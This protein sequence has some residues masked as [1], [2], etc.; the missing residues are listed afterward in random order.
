MFNGAMQR[1]IGK[2]IGEILLERGII[3][4][5][6]LDQALA[7]GKQTGKRL[8]EALVE[9]G[10]ISRD[11]VYLA[12]GVQ[13]GVNQV[14]L[15]PDMIDAEMVKRYPPKILRA[16]S[17]LPLIEVGEEVVLL[18]ADPMATEGVDKLREACPGKTFT[19]QL[20][21]RGQIDL[22]LEA[23]F[24][25]SRMQAETET[26]SALDQAIPSEQPSSLVS[27]KAILWMLGQAIAA[28]GDLLIA[29]RGSGG[30]AALILTPS[31]QQVL[32]EFE[33]AIF[34]GLFNLIH[35]TL[36]E[37]SPH[38]P[39]NWMWPK[40]IVCGQRQYAVAIRMLKTIGATGVRLRP[41]R[42]TVSDFTAIEEYALPEAE[43]QTI[44]QCAAQS[45]GRIGL[46]VV[47]PDVDWNRI[48]YHYVRAMS[49][50]LAN[51]LFISAASRFAVPSVFQYYGDGEMSER[52]LGSLSAT[53]GA[54]QVIFDAPAGWEDWVAIRST[55]YLATGMS[56]LYRVTPREGSSGV[57]PNAFWRMLE[58]C[59]EVVVLCALSSGVSIM[60]A[61][62]ASECLG[63]WR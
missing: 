6:Q 53:S 22:A 11:H 57:L 41:L 52:Y 9:L 18:T 28:D 7:H 60:N 23:V 45:C 27:A 55:S 19:L 20:A 59:P 48:L 37:F 51:V 31:G 25:A 16:F 24:P 4:Q 29:R 10:L 26:A 2:G 49:Q 34:Q 3:S 35:E 56:G 42:T 62:Q 43:E 61:A 38:L 17:L 36:I 14:D 1:V 13:Y 30:G 63:E 15:H 39:N 46:I 50:R 21:S 32:C 5:E 58:S 40:R 12:L 44:I 8:G 47:G 54:S 33:G